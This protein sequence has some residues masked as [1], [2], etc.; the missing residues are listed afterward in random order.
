MAHRLTGI[1]DLSW[2]ASWIGL[3]TGAMDITVIVWQIVHIMTDTRITQ[4]HGVVLYCFISNSYWFSLGTKSSSILVR[5]S[6][7]VVVLAV[8]LCL[9]IPPDSPSFIV[10]KIG[11]D[12]FVSLSLKPSTLYDIQLSVVWGMLSLISSATIFDI[13]IYELYNKNQKYTNEDLN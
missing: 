7:V 5:V 3:A 6:I 9:I 8:L 11:S 4:R 2:K 10:V 1:V 13:F 12:Q